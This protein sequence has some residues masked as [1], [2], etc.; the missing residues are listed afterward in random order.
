MSAKHDDAT[1]TLVKVSAND[2]RHSITHLPVHVL[3]VES[4]DALP[5]FLVAQLAAAVNSVAGI[6]HQLV[7]PEESAHISRLWQ[8]AAVPRLG[9]GHIACHVSAE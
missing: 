2:G 8:K 1:S 5:L 3:V 6:V 4:E 7:P 9:N